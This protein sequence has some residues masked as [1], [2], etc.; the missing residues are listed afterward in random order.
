MLGWLRRPSSCA[1]R[2]NRANLVR[3]SRERS[4]RTLSATSRSSACRARD[5]PR[6]SLRSQ[7]CDDRIAAEER[8]RCERHRC[9]SR[10][11]NCARSR[12]TGATPPLFGHRRQPRLRRAIGRFD[13]AE[14]ESI[15]VA[16]IARAD[17]RLRAH[18]GAVL[19]ADVLEHGACAVHGD[20][21]MV[22]DTRAKSIQTVDDGSRPIVF[23]PSSERN[24]ALVDQDPAPDG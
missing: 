10:L 20:S 23:S 21:R 6:P 9:Y 22:A 17:E 11:T 18:G 15:A 1:S 3:S 13:A 7:R 8:T 5:T 2:L 16:K 19:A 4:G 14:G 12:A 24:A